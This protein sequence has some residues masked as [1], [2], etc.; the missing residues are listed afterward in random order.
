LT[1]QQPVSSRCLCCVH[2][3]WFS[4]FGVEPSRVEPNGGEEEWNGGACSQDP[5]IGSSGLNIYLPASHLHNFF[6]ESPWNASSNLH[7]KWQN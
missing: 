6:I 4:F 7:T 2:N 5:L 3:E 1:L